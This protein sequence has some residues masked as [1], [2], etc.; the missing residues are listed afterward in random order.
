[1]QLAP[2]R[3]TKIEGTKVV[4]TVASA[5]EAKAAVKELR[6]KKRELK[7]LRGV[8][9]RRQRAVNARQDKKKKRSSWFWRL[10]AGMWWAVAA[11]IELFTVSREER[12]KHNPADIAKELQRIDETVH[13][14][15]GCVL[16]LEGKLLARG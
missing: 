8:L 1:M 2:L 16:Q 7:F 14:I 11:L 9:V 4:V 12:R 5:D 15:D 3:Y 13:N 10:L 6:H